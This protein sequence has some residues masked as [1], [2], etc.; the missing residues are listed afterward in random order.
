MTAPIGG[1]GG[2]DG[3]GPTGPCGDNKRLKN[4]VKEFEDINIEHELNE[5][6]ILSI[7]DIE[8]S[9]LIYQ[10]ALIINGNDDNGYVKAYEVKYKAYGT[11]VVYIHSESHEIIMGF[12][13]GPL[14]FTAET[15]SY[16]PQDM[17]DQQIGD[18]I[19]LSDDQFITYDF[20]GD[21][22]DFDF[23]SFDL[24]YYSTDLIPRGNVITGWTENETTEEVYQANFIS[25]TCVDAY[26]DVLDYDIG[27]TVHIAAN[28]SSSFFS[29]GFIY[30]H[31]EFDVF[32]HIV[33][34]WGNSF[35]VIAHE[36]GHALLF[37]LGFLHGITD[38]A[39]NSILIPFTCDGTFLV[40]IQFEN[41]LGE[42]L[43]DLLGV[44]IS[45][46]A[47]PNSNG[48]NWSIPSF[49]LATNNSCL[50]QYNV[51]PSS[52]ASFREYRESMG[53]F[54]FLLSQTIGIS[55]VVDLMLEAL[56][57][58]PE[59][60]EATLLDLM[61]ATTAA[62]DAKFGRCSDQGLAI[63]A[64]WDDVIC[65][66][67]FGPGNTRAEWRE[68]SAR[69][70]EYKEVC[71]FNLTGPDFICSNEDYLSLCLDG[72]LSTNYAWTIIAPN[73]TN[74]DLSGD[75]SGN[76]TVDGTCLEI[77]SIPDMPCYPQDIT[78]SVYTTIEG[79]RFVDDIIIT[80]VD[81]EDGEFKNADEF[82]YFD[83][84]EQM[85]SHTLPK[86]NFS[87][88]QIAID[89]NSSI[90]NFEYY[91]LSGQ[92]IYKS[93]HLSDSIPEFSAMRQLLIVVQ[94]DNSNRIIS[95]TKKIFIQ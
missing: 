76:G 73:S 5:Q 33:D 49:D 19:F 83:T 3:P 75:Q 48:V 34:S 71:K 9:Q 53:R 88:L 7:L 81:C 39:T 92:L 87:D 59:S 43:A 95:I 26:L 70:E 65:E 77:T 8:Y 64:A 32:I 2:P 42:S 21:N 22:V 15:V 4:H 91:N 57:T 66:E 23:N 46:E 38:C 55:D 89:R 51:N 27:K 68:V 14:G 40:D 12:H 47:D 82:D 20:N 30:I 25:Y 13:L 52:N 45:S 10:N 54:F 93:N 36:F 62:M 17:R 44:Y 60:P 78:I 24:S 6:Q 37:D 79:E 85:Q 11:N 58:I 18:D 94:K 35:E 69:I 28:A 31:D 29:G 16:G 84:Y 1:P 74:F 80:I 67:D 86:T 63:R 61:D 41:G 56:N 90:S 50:D 72:G